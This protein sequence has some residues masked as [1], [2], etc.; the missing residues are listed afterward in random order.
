MNDKAFIRL[1]VIVVAVMLLL[2]AAHVFYAIHAYEQS[3]IIQFVAREI[4]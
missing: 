1:I 3:S 2:T 4:W